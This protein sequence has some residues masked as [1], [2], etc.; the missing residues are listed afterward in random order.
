MKLLIC[1]QAVDK[2]HPILG[3][4]HGWINEFARHF[5][6][7]DVICL[8]EGKHELPTHVHIHS[9]GKEKGTS[10]ITQLIKFYWY[11]ARAF[12]SRPNYVFFHMGAIYN[13]LAAPFFLI[14]RLFSIKF[15]WWKAHGHINRQGKLALSF[16]DKVFTSTASGF[17]IETRKRQIVGQAIDTNI[18]ITNNELNRDPKHIVF[19]GRIMPIKHIEV[20]VE[21]A[22]KLHVRDYT[23]SIIGPIGDE[24]YYLDLKEQAAE[25]NVRFLG[26]KTQTELVSIYQ[27]AGFFLNTSLTHSMDK[28]VLEAM[29]CG[30][31][32][33]TAN[34]A[35]KDMLE[36]KG[37]F[38]D[39]QNVEDYVRT[40]IEL[41]G[42][43]QTN[44][45]QKLRDSV[46]T[47]HSLK[48]FTKRIF[49]VS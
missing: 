9:L 14:R 1:T 11:F 46:V 2:D 22:R 43:D 24:D 25:A 34:R 7:V 39:T 30:C 27:E 32:P 40:I 19:V 31:I 15:Y 13:I 17:P 4:F 5:N 45:R 23:F 10:K 44:L 26:S 3:F 8:E 41:V 28:T 48:T 33:L 37:L 12:F 16:V 47:E 36:K 29:L 42:R 38:F 35:F 49:N 18:F 20:F 21:I 6:R